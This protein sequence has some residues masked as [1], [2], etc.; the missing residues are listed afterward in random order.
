MT[1]ETKN[2][3]GRPAGS[4]KPGSLTARLLD[5]DVGAT[6]LEADTG[7]ALLTECKRALRNVKS[8]EPARAYEMRLYLGVPIKVDAM[9]IRFYRIERTS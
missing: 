2:S 7:E 3:R 1:T 6:V 4:F 9:P 5:L 8:I